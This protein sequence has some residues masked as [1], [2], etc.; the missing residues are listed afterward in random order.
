MS[1]ELDFDYLSEQDIISELDFKEFD[2]SD[3]LGVHDFFHNK[4]TT[5]HHNRIST[6]RTVRIDGKIVALFA[7]SMSA[8]SLQHLESNERIDLVTPLRYPAMLIGQLGVDKKFRDKGIGQQI[9]NFCL[10]LAQDIGERVA[11]RYV[12]LQTNPDKMVLYNKMGFT[13]SP[14]LPDENNKI[15]MYRKL[16]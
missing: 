6:I 4:A 12:I 7:I 15:W 16:I 9:C 8:I 13:K 14:K 1:T 3:P 5:Y 10:G 2:D 11:C